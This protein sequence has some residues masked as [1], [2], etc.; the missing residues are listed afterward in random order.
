VSICAH[1]LK[2]P[3]PERPLP[4]GKLEHA[5]DRGTRIHNNGELFVKGKGKLGP[6]L[7][8]FF[9]AEYEALYR[10]YKE[11]KAFLEDEWGMTQ[12]W[13]PCDFKAKDVWL[14]LKLDAMVRLTPRE[15]VVIDVK[16]GRRMGNEIK[17]AEQVQL[18]QLVTFLRFPEIEIVHVELW[19]TD[20]DDFYTQT[21]TRD[22][23]LRFK[24]KFNERGTSSLRSH[25]QGTPMSK[26]TRPSSRAN[27]AR[28]EN[29]PLPSPNAPALSACT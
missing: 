13:E 2:I 24:K 8:K 6:E 26:R 4:E 29:L 28:T 21:Y 18:Y 9:A 19:Y 12:E 16:T 17:H 15:A 27:T 25:S 22:Q 14:R 7:R 11:K 1:G 5:N 23:G 20:I 10:L 3:E